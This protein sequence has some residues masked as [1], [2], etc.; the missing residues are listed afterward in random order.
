MTEVP[1]PEKQPL[2]PWLLVLAATGVGLVLIAVV[3]SAALIIG[4]RHD[5]VSGLESRMPD[6]SVLRVEKLSWGRTHTFEY[7]P[8]NGMWEFFGGGTGLHSSRHTSDR[9]QLVIWMT[10]RSAGGQP[11]DFDWWQ[12]SV[13][14]DAHGHEVTDFSPMLLELGNGSS[15]HGGDRP[16]KANRTQYRNWVASSSFP[17]FPVKGGRFELRVKNLS[18]DVVATFELTHPS[19]PKAPEWSPE[20][21]PVSRVNGDF[22]VTLNSVKT[23]QSQWTRNGLPQISWHLDP[24]MSFQWQGQPTAEWSV[25][26][27]EWSD[28]FGNIW[29]G[30]E[31]LLSPKAP[32]WKLKVGVFKHS[33]AQFD[34]AETAALKNIALPA[35]GTA[36]ARSEIATIGSVSVRPLMVGGDGATSYGIAANSV[37]HRGHFSSSTSGQALGANYRIVLRGDNREVRCSVDCSCPHLLWDVS[38]LTS[39]HRLYV[40]AKDDQSRSVATQMVYTGDANL[41]LQLLKPEPDATSL[42]L[43]VIVHQ[44]NEFEFLVKPPDLGTLPPVESSR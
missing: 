13:V 12:S 25:Q 17:A 20:P 38:G 37:R 3:I 22:G 42:D 1:Q 44:G 5:E 19:P 31:R 8:P 26:G 30:H 21:F 39:R 32:A 16:L 35:S 41:Q 29:D 40:Q 2:N 36:T 7:K 14:V 4:A 18:G 10:R 6:G 9:D 15:Q 24:V 34:Q 33:N 43:T 27:V 23:H 28:P 11:V